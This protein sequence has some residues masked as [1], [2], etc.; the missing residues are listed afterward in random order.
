MVRRS[1]DPAPAAARAAT[2]PCPAPAIRARDGT[3]TPSALRASARDGRKTFA[4][5]RVPRTADGPAASSAPSVCQSFARAPT[6]TA[7][8]PRPH[9][10]PRA[11][12]SPQ[13]PC[14][15]RRARPTA[16]GPT[17]PPL[18]PMPAPPVPFSLGRRAPRLRSALPSIAPATTRRRSARIV[19]ARARPARHKNKPAPSCAR[20][21]AVGRGADRCAPTFSANPSI[22]NARPQRLAP[23]RS[24]QGRSPSF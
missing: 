14:A 1:R 6:D 11:H 21:R 17:P 19:S 22:S 2:A 24:V 23:R 12:A 16:G 4:P 8:S 9:S 20:A 3:R 13:P 7:R 15:P 18:C 5:S 10:A